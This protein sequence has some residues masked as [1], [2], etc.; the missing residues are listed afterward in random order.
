M[1]FKSILTLI[2]ATMALGIALCALRLVDI[3]YSLSDIRDQAIL[4]ADVKQYS[5]R[6]Q[7]DKGIDA[8]IKLDA[9]QNDFPLT[10]D[11]SIPVGKPKPAAKKLEIPEKGG[12]VIT[13]M[14][15]IVVDPEGN[16]SHD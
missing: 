16:E 1:I 3:S 5:D 8:G 11:I 2:F 9:R 6:W 12:K 15:P 13:I 4:M 10:G 14:P 7:V